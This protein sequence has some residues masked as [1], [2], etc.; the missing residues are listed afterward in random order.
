MLIILV[1]NAIF[2]IY[3]VRQASCGRDRLRA[4]SV[5]VKDL[6]ER[7]LERSPL[8]AG[9]TAPIILLLALILHE[10]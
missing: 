1:V 2:I 6:P 4:R 8:E 10:C 5:P 3:G 7:R 9:A